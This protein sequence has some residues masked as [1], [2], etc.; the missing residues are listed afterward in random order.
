M[1]LIRQPRKGHEDKGPQPHISRIPMRCKTSCP[2]R[3]ISGNTT[4]LE[5]S[6]AAGT[7]KGPSGEM[8]GSAPASARNEGC[9]GA[10]LC[11]FETF[12]AFPEGCEGGL[13]GFYCAFE[14]GV[15]RGCC[16]EGLVL[17]IP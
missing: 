4:P 17:E 3:H 14:W 7:P 16:C 6:S 12:K 1:Q 5:A 11:K 9:V 15:G 2:I 13:N 8:G 10:E